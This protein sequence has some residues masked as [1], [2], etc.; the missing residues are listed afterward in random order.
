[1]TH[2]NVEGT[3]RDVL[4]KLMVRNYGVKD[5]Q[6]I[7]LKWTIES[8]NGTCGFCDPTG[9]SDSSPGWPKFVSPD[10]V[11]SIKQR[12]VVAWAWNHIDAKYLEEAAIKRGDV[13]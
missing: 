9:V 8:R 5:V 13:E 4:R 10:L 7:E 6:V 1:M 2:P 3:V 11:D 12:P